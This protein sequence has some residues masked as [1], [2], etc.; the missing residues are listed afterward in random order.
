MAEVQ[1]EIAK[2]G[3]TAR[4]HKISLSHWLD[5]GWSVVEKE[6]H[7]LEDEESDQ[8][9]DVP[10]PGETIPASVSEPVGAHAL[11][12]SKSDETA[13]GELTQS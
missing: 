9:V 10:E 4:V 5:K 3:Q 8:Q 12:E 7:K 13:Q 2:D 11:P 1:I 6:V